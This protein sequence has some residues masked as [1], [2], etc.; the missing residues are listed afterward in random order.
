MND[1]ISRSALRKEVRRCKEAVGKCA[2]HDYMVGYASAL[3]GFEGQIAEAPAV[4]AAPKWINA[5]ETLPDEGIRVLVSI[6][7][8]A[9][10]YVVRTGTRSTLHTWMELYKGETMFYWAELPEPPQ[11]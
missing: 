9:D 1:L 8:D 2:N 11:R 3:S 10:R 7:Y 5:K 6:R 4:A